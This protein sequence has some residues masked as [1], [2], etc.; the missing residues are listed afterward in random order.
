[1][2]SMKLADEGGLSRRSL[3]GALVGAIFLAVVSSYWSYLRLMYRYGGGSLHEW[4]TT[5][6]TRNLYSNWTMAASGRG[7]AGEA[8]LIRHDGGRRGLDDRA[9]LPSPHLPLVGRCTR[10]AT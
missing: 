3:A 5:Y 9:H 1:M 7:G 8:D 6:Y 4:F 10:S 2:Q